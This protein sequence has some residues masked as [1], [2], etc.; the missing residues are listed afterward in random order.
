MFALSTK[1]CETLASKSNVDFTNKL[2]LLL[3]GHSASHQR[4]VHH[5]PA[6]H[7]RHGVQDLQAFPEREAPIPYRVHGERQEA[8]ARVHQPQVPP[9]AVWRNPVHTQRHWW[10]VARTT[11]YV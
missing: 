3:G 7:L 10:T 6:V 2:L 4:P 5:Q 8:A 11:P 1:A 9:G